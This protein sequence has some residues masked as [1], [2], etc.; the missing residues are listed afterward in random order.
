M[1]GSLPSSSGA[2]VG[3]YIGIRVSGL[4]CTCSR[5]DL[6][7]WGSFLLISDLYI[8]IFIDYAVPYKVISATGRD[9]DE[10]Y[11]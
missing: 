2:S 4:G 7:F 9:Y 3:E 8:Y 11:L 6:S 10:G 1:G 5:K